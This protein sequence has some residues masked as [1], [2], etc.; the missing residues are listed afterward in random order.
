MGVHL[1]FQVGD[2]KKDEEF[3]WPLPGTGT[4]DGLACLSLYS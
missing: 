1:Q 2:G 4:G 3:G